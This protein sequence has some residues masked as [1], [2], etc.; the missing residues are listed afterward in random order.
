[1][2]DARSCCYD[3]YT[4]DAVPQEDVCCRVRLSA[5]EGPS[6]DI[7][8]LIVEK[9]CWRWGT[10]PSRLG[11]YGPWRAWLTMTICYDSGSRLW[12]QAEGSVVEHK[13]RAVHVA[14][15]NLREQNRPSKRKA[16]ATS[17]PHP[18]SGASTKRPRT[19]ALSRASSSEPD[20]ASCSPQGHRRERERPQPMPPVRFGPATRPPP[21]PSNSLAS[22]PAL[23]TCP[24]Q[25]EQRRRAL[26]PECD[27]P[28]DTSD[29]SFSYID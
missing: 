11:R 10:E 21:K 1:M 5:E 2:L 26:S 8:H 12:L 6:P 16:K 14:E 27:G 7:A 25:P 17:H 23:P 28:E 20:E 18:R 24:Q 15:K 9:S 22:A 3:L 29:F 19:T 4:F 13:P